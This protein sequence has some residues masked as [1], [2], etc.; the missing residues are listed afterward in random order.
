MNIRETTNLEL[1]SWYA[2][3]CDGEC[4]PHNQFGAL[5]F[6]VVETR[7]ELLR[8]MEGDNIAKEQI[9]KLQAEKKTLMHDLATVNIQLG[10][11]K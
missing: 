11:D 7:K 5:H 9:E 6:D 3:L 4:N 1:L 2:S 8:R 10:K